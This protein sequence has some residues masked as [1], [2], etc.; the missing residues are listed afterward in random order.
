MHFKIELQLE[1][2]KV[3]EFEIGYSKTEL[4][5]LFLIPGL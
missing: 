1:D 5:G 4:I 2:L 3:T